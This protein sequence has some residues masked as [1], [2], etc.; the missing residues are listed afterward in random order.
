[1]A[2]ITGTDTP[3]GDFFDDLTKT[4]WA[5]CEPRQRGQRVLVQG[6]AG[7]VGQPLLTSAV[8]RGGSSQFHYK[9]GIPGELMVFS[10][11]DVVVAIT[12]LCF[13]ADA[14]GA[15][16]EMARVLRPR[17]TS[18]ARR[19]RAVPLG[20]D[21]LLARLVWLIDLDGG[22]FPRCQ[23]AAHACRT[24]R[25]F[26]HDHLR[27]RILPADWQTRTDVGAT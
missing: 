24:G 23:R 27:R 2:D 22:P 8:C 21:P 11:F 5:D 12:V 10:S 26:G 18:R 15:V 14:S 13:I 4:R 17:R 25:A 19:A 9:L 3:F 20:H 1:M 7:A 6:A 16:R